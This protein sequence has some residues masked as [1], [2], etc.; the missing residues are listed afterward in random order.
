MQPQIIWQKFFFFFVAASGLIVTAAYKHFHDMQAYFNLC[1]FH[2]N[3][4]F[5]S[6]P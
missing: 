5:N 1:F 6:V 3:I 2:E 4:N